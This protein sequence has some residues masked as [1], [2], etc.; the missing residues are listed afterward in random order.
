ME[1]RN[2]IKV[3]VIEKNDGISGQII[4]YSGGLNFHCCGNI[5]PDSHIEDIESV[6]PDIVILGPDV[7]GKSFN[8]C[9]QNLRIIDP[10]M[11]ILVCCDDGNSIDLENCSFEGVHELN[12]DKCKDEL[13]TKIES[14]LL[15]KEECEFLPDIPIIIGESSGIRE[16]R[17]KIK[18]VADKNITV[19]ITGETGTGKE[20]VAQAVHYYS[21]RNKGPFVKINCGSL[22][23]EL[24]ES[25]VFGFQK[26][27][28]TDAHKNKP[29]RI[30]EAHQ[31]TL[32]IDEIGNLSLSLQ[33]KFLQVLE[34]KTF[35]RLGSVG[36]T[37][38]DTRV[39]AATNA[40][41]SAKVSD[42]TFRKD[43]FYRLNVV[44][45]YVPPLRDRKSDIPLLVHFFLSKYCFDLKKEILDVPGKV[46]DFFNNYHWPGNVREVENITRR[47]IIMRDWSFVFDELKQVEKQEAKK[48]ISEPIFPHANWNQERLNQYF[49]EDNI[50]LKM[51]TK[52]Y[53]SEAEK[54]A[55]INT[56]CR[57]DWNRKKASKLLGVS[58]KTL[59][60]R[61]NEFQIKPS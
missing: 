17:E 3:L 35:S 19:L 57:T 2:K 49:D 33:A 24:L 32:F 50:S 54:E 20:L 8:R 55:I 6:K 38:V 7:Q 9:V 44:N 42:L 14:A 16:I 46:M 15:L 51:I 22:P 27:A 41:L 39:I 5:G 28:F 59:L 56:L 34:D 36:D 12:W 37:I 26:G 58:Y 13:Q 60:N 18:R 30:E 40:D 52:A 1:K 45:I 10:I 4:K 31:G 43:L 23:E 47:S 21:L 11:P 29:G 48:D 25:E 61:I 53:V